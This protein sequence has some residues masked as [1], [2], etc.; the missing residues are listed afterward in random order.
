MI[1]FHSRYN[2][3]SIMEI[4]CIPIGPLAARLVAGVAPPVQEVEGGEQ[5]LISIPNPARMRISP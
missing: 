4:D 3:G 2:N 1:P 5:A